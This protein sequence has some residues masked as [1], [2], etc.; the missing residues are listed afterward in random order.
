M[1]QFLRS[2]TYS[3]ETGIVD[4]EITTRPVHSVLL[5]DVRLIDPASSFDGPIC[6]GLTGGEIIYR[7]EFPQDGDYDE[8]LEA[9]GLWL[10]P[11][12]I[13]LCMRP[14]EP[15][16]THKATLHSELKAAAA[17]GITMC[18]IPPDTC[19]VIDDTSVIEHIQRIA[20]SV[21]GASVRM[22]GA[23][24]LGLS[25]KAL[26]EMSALQRAG[27][28]GVTNALSPITNLTV[29]LRSLEYASGLGLTVH[30][31]PQD[32][33]LTDGG[34]AHAGAASLRLGLPGIPTSAETVAIGQWIALAE[35]CGA[36]IHFCRLSAA[37]SISL[38]EDAKARGLP[39]TCDVAAHQLFFT[40]NDV[41]EFNPFCHVMPPLRTDFDREM[42]RSGLT[43]GAIDAICSDHQPHD[44]DAKTGPFELT[45]PGMSTI[46]TLLPLAL[47]LVRCGTL[48]PLQMAK[49]LSQEPARILGLPYPSL[50]VGNQADMVLI[51]PERPWIVDAESLQ[52]RGHNTPLFGQTIRGRAVRVFQSGHGG[53]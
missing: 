48:T 5:R 45:E 30:V 34:C 2:E 50:R 19:P 4:L 11:G 3:N 43:S 9:G 44:Q 25:G 47:E 31:S 33:A 39:V 8:V 37:R 53:L 49:K 51:N 22:L 21:G 27:C 46:E 1:I 12:I 18:C 23:L 32:T 13:D 40:E 6:V 36:T 20:K 16:A 38:I 42:L 15:G 41:E 10:M 28:V 35:D 26:A 24:T 7:G 29:A 52:S 14:R 17:A